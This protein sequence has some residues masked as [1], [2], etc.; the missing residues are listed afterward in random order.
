MNEFEIID[1][2]GYIGP[3]LLFIFIVYYLQTTPHYM[4][5]YIVGTGFSICLNKLLKLICKEARP[6]NQ[7]ILSKIEIEQYTRDEIYGMPSGHAQSAFFS[8]TYLY[9]VSKNKIGL[10]LSL[11]LG[12]ITLY[13]RWKYRAHTVS[14]LAIGTLV[15]TLFGYFVFYLAYRSLRTS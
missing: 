9:L 2:I 12:C 13:Q 5:M 1:Y 6:E 11:F 4:W 15:G 14:Q 8:I 7:M 3:L 10:V